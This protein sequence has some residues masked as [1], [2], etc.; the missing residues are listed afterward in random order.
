[1]AAV[2]VGIT[3][4]FRVVLAAVVAAAMLPRPTLAGHR[5]KLELQIQVAALAAEVAAAGRE[6]RVQVVPVVLVS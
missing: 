3:Q 5:Q 6:A 2:A 1:V 4:H